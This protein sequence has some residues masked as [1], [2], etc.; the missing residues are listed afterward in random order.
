M[1]KLFNRIASTALALS[2]VA[3]MSTTT[4]FASETAN[5]DY[6]G[7]IHFYKE[8]DPSST[9]MCDAIF[10]HTADITLTDDTAA[11]TFYVAYPIPAFPDQGT[12]GTIK[13]VVVTYNETAYTGVSDITTKAEK[14]FDTTSALFGITADESYPTQSVTL[15]LPR[16]AVSSFADGLYTSTYVNV[17]MNS[18][19]YFYVKITD[20]VA[21]ST[22]SDD[23]PAETTP[24]VT[25]TTTKQVQVSAEV[26]APQATYMVTI[27]E[28]VTLGTLSADADSSVEYSVEVTAENLGTGYVEVVTATDGSLVSGENSLAFSNSFGTQKTSENAVFTGIFTV[29]AA[30]VQNAA[31]GNYTGTVNFNINYYA[32]Q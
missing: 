9:S 6:T 15:E 29:K 24:V 21:V 30:D 2:L 31:A 19:Q 25:E 26:A 18:T 8:S 1:K 11:V 10:A 12:D 32:A 13:D 7:T 3:G 20:L 16:E 14:V 5:G 4:A 27:P 22:E 17:V 23:T 28:S